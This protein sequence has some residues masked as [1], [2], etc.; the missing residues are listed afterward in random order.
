MQMYLARG[1]LLSPRN[2]I[3]K[4]LKNKE[5]LMNGKRS[6]IVHGSGP[7][8]EGI[9][10]KNKETQVNKNIYLKVRR[11]KVAGFTDILMIAF[12]KMA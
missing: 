3:V 6:L 5:T 2:L 7:G 11:R 4:K 8:V 12:H 10:G 9:T 1:T